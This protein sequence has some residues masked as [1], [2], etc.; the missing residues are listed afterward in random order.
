MTL[1]SIIRRSISA[2]LVQ[3]ISAV[4][5]QLAIALLISAGHATPARAMCCPFPCVGCDID[6]SGQ[7]TFIVMDRE[8]GLV[9]IIPN[10]R[11]TGPANSFALV[12]PTPS[13]P[14][15]HPVAKE[16]WQQATGLTAPP[17]RMFS[18]GGPGCGSEEIAAVPANETDA[19]EIIATRSVGSFLAT[20]IR[21]TDPLG[22][23][24]WLRSN[25]FEVTEPEA[26][27]LGRYVSRGWVF[28]AMKLDPAS[29]EAQR[30]A[31]GWDVNVNPVEFRYAAT[32]VEVPLE[33]MAINRDGFF[34]VAFYV[35]D[36]H[37]VELTGFQTNYVNR[38][39]S[40]EFNAID[41]RYPEVALHLHAGA[42]LTRLDRTFQS[43][44]IMAGSQMVVRAASDRE[45]NWSNI[46]SGPVVP[47]ESILF[48]AL[49]V[50]LFRRRLRR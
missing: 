47:L 3:S 43:N 12:V 24:T 6:N 25:G 13:V 49:P 31:G 30:P 18:S 29:P 9:G 20:T 28:T 46:P 23:V 16:I 7:A 45:L 26:Q 50:G 48:L 4:L 8:N 41:E 35:V 37:R 38:I 17:A 40:R 10:I 19:I 36:D 1:P 34:P 2:A 21:A 15:L 44:E 32:Q 5:V 27:A 22:L 14:T 11:L 42:F 33:L 39:S